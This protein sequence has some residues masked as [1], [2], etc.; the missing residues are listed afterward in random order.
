LAPYPLFEGVGYDA[1]YS[2][3]Y[4]MHLDNMARYARIQLGPGPVGYMRDT[5]DL[6]QNKLLDTGIQRE[7][8]RREIPKIHTR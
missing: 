3:I 6:L 8:C 2:G 7:K 4:H 1:R 5:V